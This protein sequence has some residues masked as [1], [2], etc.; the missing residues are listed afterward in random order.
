MIASFS[1]S[2][3]EMGSDSSE[4]VRFE[5]IF[6]LSSATGRFIFHIWKPFKLMKFK[7]TRTYRENIK[8][9]YRLSNFESAICFFRITETYDMKFSIKARILIRLC[10]RTSL[11]A[12]CSR[13]EGSVPP[14]RYPSGFA[15]K[16]PD[17]RANYC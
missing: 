13:I 12:E 1:N 15:K 6:F 4:K 16:V 17:C 2:T 14:F 3:S 7:D 9:K 11:W 5:P 8:S 10:H